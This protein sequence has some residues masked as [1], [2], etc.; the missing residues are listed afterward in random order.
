M[1]FEI[2]KRF[3]AI[4][5]D[6]GISQKSMA[7][8]IGVSTRYYQDLENSL[9]EPSFGVVLNALN[10]LKMT[11][12]E[13]LEERESITKGELFLEIVP[14]LAALD[15]EEMRAIAAP[16]RAAHRR[17]TSRARARAQ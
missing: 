8:L 7:E 14:L 11:F 6:R 10:G 1:N 16:I 4:R 15:E 3:R 2:G 13:F 17:A 5:A 9:K 12:A